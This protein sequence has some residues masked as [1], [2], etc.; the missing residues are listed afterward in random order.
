MASLRAATTFSAIGNINSHDA[1]PTITTP[2]CVAGDL[3]FV[4]V[5]F[6]QGTGNVTIYPPTGM[7]T[8]SS[9]GTSANRLGALY[10]AVVVNPSDFSAGILLRSGNTATRIAAVAWT[11]KP[12]GTEY[13]T[14]AD[15]NTS[16]PDWNGSTMSTDTFPSG[17][18]GTMFL[19]VSM[20]NK[21]AS[22]TA[23]GRRCCW[24]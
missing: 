24:A 9:P 1:A 10:A 13:F 18:T 17:A 16:G 20:D 14:L 7:T 2:T 8:I 15:V 4:A 6:A 5:F 12:T 19:G 23:T 3:L 21:A 11:I 22:T